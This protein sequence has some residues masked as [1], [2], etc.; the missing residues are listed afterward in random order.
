[1]R[2]CKVC[3]REQKN[4]VCKACIANAGNNIGKGLKVVRN[5]AFMAGPVVI[6]E[7]L[8]KKNQANE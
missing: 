1:M 7:A 3:K 8:K 4:L 2:M 5:I 6:N